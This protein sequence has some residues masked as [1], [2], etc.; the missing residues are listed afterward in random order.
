MTRDATPATRA[1]MARAIGLL[2]AEKE[3]AAWDALDA[4]DD[5]QLDAVQA[6]A[7]NLGTIASEIVGRRH[8]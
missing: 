3:D 7:G 5:F 4:L 1:T 6:L 2:W 8:G